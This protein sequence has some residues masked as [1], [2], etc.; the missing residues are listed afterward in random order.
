MTTSKN[1]QA[2]DVLAISK[3][4]YRPS[5]TSAQGNDQSWEIVKKMVSKG[6]CTRLDLEKALAEQRNHKPFVGYAL[7][8]GWLVA[9]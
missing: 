2:T 1:V 6:K 3:K 4:P 8:R 5:A 9:K 7:R